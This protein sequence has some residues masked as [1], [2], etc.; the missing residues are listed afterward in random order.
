MIKSITI[1]DRSYFKTG[2]KIKKDGKDTDVV[3]VK[4]KVRFRRVKV[5]LSDGEVLTY[6]GYPFIYS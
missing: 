6:T 2:E 1:G 3:V 4:I 5:Y